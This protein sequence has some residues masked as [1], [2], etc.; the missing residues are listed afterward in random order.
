MKTV[1]A[2]AVAAIMLFPT[3]ALAQDET[4]LIFGI[5]Y[6]CNQ[7]ME[8]QADEIVNGTLG[9]IAQKHVDL[10]HLTGWAWL[11]HVQG[12]AW[13]RV[14]AMLGTDRDMM[15]DMRAA[16]I[17][18][19]TGQHAEAA[20]QLSRACPGHDDYIWTNIVSSTLDTDV[21]GDASM[22]TY[23]VCDISKEGRTNEIFEEVIAPLYQK[24]IDMGHLASY[25]FFAHRSGGR[26]RRLET[27]SGP[28]HKTL[29]NMQDAI[30]EEA[31]TNAALQMQEFTQICGSHVDYMW[32]NAAQQ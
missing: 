6:R 23:Y 18:E 21:L 12:G 16:I 1:G 32:E 31:F 2:A 28:D 26:F 3:S 10:G 9:P 24:H 15:F 4:S 27:F 30:F 25:G 29:M 17:A 20:E 7:T 14:F 11:S 5:Y 22:S 8:T 13:R 19:F